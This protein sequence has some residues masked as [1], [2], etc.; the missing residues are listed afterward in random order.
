MSHNKPS[1][2]TAATSQVHQTTRL[3]QSE[4]VG[5]GMRS[6]R[7]SG[8]AWIERSSTELYPGAI[9]RERNGMTATRGGA[10]P[11]SV[12]AARQECETGLAAER[13]HGE[14][15]AG[16]N[17]L[18]QRI[19]FRGKTQSNGDPSRALPGTTPRGWPLPERGGR[20]R[21]LRRRRLRGACS[22][23]RR[24]GARPR[25]DGI[26]GRGGGGSE[27]SGRI[28]PHQIATKRGAC[29]AQGQGQNRP[30]TRGRDGAGPAGGGATRGR[31]G[32]RRRG[33]ARSYR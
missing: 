21:C 27:S 13:A 26:D 11:V 12:F 9:L 14:R 32:R 24:G 4:Q 23:R 19:H 29:A 5:W 33:G 25:R 22:G 2:Q 30:S 10:P 3:N 31:G 8:H 7:L 20:C 17:G 1:G 18:A 16:S 6:P 15:R 28:E